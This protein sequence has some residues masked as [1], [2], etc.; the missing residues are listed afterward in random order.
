MCRNEDGAIAGV[1]TMGHIVLG[2]L[3]SA[4]LGYYVFAPYARQ[5]VMTEGVDLAVRHAFVVIGLHRLEANVQP[6]NVASIALVERLGF[7]REG[8]SER[9]LMVAGRWRDHVRYAILA[10]DVVAQPNP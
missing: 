9:Y 7:R 8:Y 10:E 5:G 1:V 3:R 6:D 2:H 4:Y